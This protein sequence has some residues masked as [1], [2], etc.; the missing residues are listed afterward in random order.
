MAVTLGA[1]T[2]QDGSALCSA[3]RESESLIKSR[4]DT[5]ARSPAKDSAQLNADIGMQ[6][7]DLRSKHRELDA[8]ADELDRLKPRL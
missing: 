5:L 1:T 8:L 2:L 7:T 4:I 3:V 6:L